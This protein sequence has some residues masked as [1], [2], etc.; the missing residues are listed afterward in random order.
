[1]RECD[2]HQEI[3]RNAVYRVSH[4]GPAAFNID[5]AYLVSGAP[6]PVKPHAFHSPENAD[7][8]YV[9]FERQPSGVGWELAPRPRRSVEPQHRPTLRLSEF[10]EAQESAVGHD[11]R[12]FDAGR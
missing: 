10:G 2:G 11:D 5:N 12:A 1:M 3:S 6:P 4:V 8:P 7:Q 9:A